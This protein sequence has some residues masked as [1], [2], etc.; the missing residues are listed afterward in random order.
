[1]AA[2]RPRVTKKQRQQA[3]EI[4]DL[5]GNLFEDHTIGLYPVRNEQGDHY[6]CPA[7][8]ARKDTMGYAMGQEHIND[9]QHD[10]RCDVHLLYRLYQDYRAQYDPPQEDQPE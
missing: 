5:L 6:A 2:K 3:Q 7:C 4:W 1:M 9:I 8:T 10:D